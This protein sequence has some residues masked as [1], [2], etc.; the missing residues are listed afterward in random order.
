L[1]RFELFLNG[2]AFLVEVTKING[3]SAL[4]TVNGTQYEVGF[5]DLSKLELP[6]VVKVTEQ[7]KAASASGRQTCLVESVNGSI[8]VKAPLPGLI[9]DVKVG[10]GDKV[11][12]GDVLLVI[13]T[14]KMENNVVSP[15]PGTIKEISVKK[16]DTV[17]E[18]VPLVVIAG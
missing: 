12:P 6:K 8:T 18:G 14:M 9:I 5:N 10:V 4:V 15:R 13:E 17:N 11:K 2:K 16:G 7:Q 3:E 1:K